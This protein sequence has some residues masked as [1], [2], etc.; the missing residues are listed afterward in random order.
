MSNKDSSHALTSLPMGFGMALLQNR[1]ARNVFDQLPLDRQMKI[2]DGTH[3]IQSKQ[4]MQQYV[5][6][7][8]FML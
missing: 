6:K 5:S 3:D 1:N 7:I 2:I 4:E 8:P